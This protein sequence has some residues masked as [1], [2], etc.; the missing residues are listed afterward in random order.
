MTDLNST[1]VT[2][3]QSVD[4]PIH[5]FTIILNGQPFIQYH[6]PVFQQLK[7]NW[8]WHII[9][10]V[11]ALKHDT[12]WS[13]ASGGRIDDALHENGLSNDGT[14]AYLDQI[15]QQ[16]SKQITLYRPAPGSFWDGKREMVNAPL[17]N[18]QAEGL[19]WQV[20][21]DELWTIAQ[22]ERTRQMFLTDP[23]KTA[24]FFWCNFF[25]GENLLVSSRHCYSQDPRFEWLRVWRYQPGMVWAKHEP[26]TLVQADGQDVA[27]INPFLHAE[28][29]KEG[30]VFQHFAYVTPEQLQ[31]KQRYYGYQNAVQQWQQLQAQ[32]DFPVYLRDYFAWVKDETVVDRVE[33]CGVVPIAHRHPDNGSWQ[34]QTNISPSFAKLP[35]PKIAVDGVAFQLLRGGISR[36]W[37]SLL[38]EWV[39]TGFTKH[40]LVLDRGGTAPKIPGVRYCKLP[41]YDEKLSG[42]DSQILQEVCDREQVACLI[43]SYYT[44]PTATPTVFMVH[45]MIPEVMQADLNQPAW[46][47]KHYCILHAGTYIAVSKNSAQDLVRCYPTIQPDRVHVALNGLSPDFAPASPAAVEQWRSQFNITRPYV[48]FVGERFGFNGYKNA[49]YLFKAM[50]EWDKQQKYQIVCIGGPLEIEPE[51]AKWVKPESVKV[52]RLSDQELN[53]AYS[54]AIALVYPSLYEGFGLPI[55]EAMA[56]GCPVITCRNSSIPE[57]AGQS[58]IYV[59]GIEVSQ[60]IEAL[61][62][63]QVP[64][65]RQALVTAGLAQAQ[66]FSWQKMAAS[67]AEILTQV[68]TE[69]EQQTMPQPSA[70][71]SELRKLQTEL[72]HQQNPHL[73]VLRVDQ[74]QLLQLQLRSLLTEV[75]DM[76]RNF[77][78]QLRGMVLGVKQ[79]LG[80]PSIDEAIIDSNLPAEAQILQVKSRIAWIQTSKFWQLQAAWLQLRSMRESDKKLESAKAFGDRST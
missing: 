63:V 56:C 62:K 76:E 43:S 19:L 58:A 57:V 4:L 35:A 29:E 69:V 5:F 34:F 51:L 32:P 9:E 41:L 46:R 38:T 59:N 40:L 44:A 7:C 18:L 1:D 11:A 26:P 80:K 36:V 17:P 28:T 39:K 61:E 72:Q 16:Y 68:C 8:H 74:P 53:A 60:L 66:Q 54:G 24:A 27:K 22:I 47:E 70:V 42:L 73:M 14:T 45:D 55:L 65:V 3:R 75:E 2:S 20:D 64:Q 33:D 71:W 30:L 21:A 25:V 77:F 6:L 12:A 78:W 50:R 23:A 49:E 52:L 37:R 13:V 48:C 10:G 15:A 31:F 67:V 79:I